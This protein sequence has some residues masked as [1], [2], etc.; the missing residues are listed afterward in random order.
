MRKLAFLILIVLAIAIQFNSCKHEPTQPI[1][2]GTD[3]TG[4]GHGNN[5]GS[6]NNQTNDS[7]CFNTQILPLIVNNCATSGCHDATSRVEGLNLTTYS[8]IRRMV[9][10]T[11]M[12]GSLLSVAQSTGRNRMPPPPMAPMDTAAINLI[13]KWMTQGALN[14]ICTDANGCDSSNVTYSSKI[15]SIVNTNCK[16]CHQATNAGGG[17]SLTSYAEVKSSVQNGTFMCT[18]HQ[19]AGCSP[20]PKGGKLTACDIRKLEIWIAN[21]YPQ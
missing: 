9:N 17:I 8:A 13:K 5:N 11:T 14:R 7:I 3:T 12:K 15:A 16:G 6:E 18:V 19:N 21:G 20:M 10:P 2:N 4:N 1:Y